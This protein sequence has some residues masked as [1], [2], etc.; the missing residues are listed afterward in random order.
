M[1]TTETWIWFLLSRPMFTISTADREMKTPTPTRHP[2]NPTSPKSGNTE[3]FTPSTSTHSSIRPQ[4]QLPQRQPNLQHPT[5]TSWLV[6]ALPKAHCTIYPTRTEEPPLAQNTNTS[7]ITKRTDLDLSHSGIPI[8]EFFPKDAKQELSTWSDY[9]VDLINTVHRPPNASA[10]EADGITAEIELLERLY[11]DGIKGNWLSVQGGVGIDF[12]AGLAAEVRHWQEIREAMGRGKLRIV[13]RW[14]ESILRDD[15]DVDMDMDME[16]GDFEIS[17]M[18]MGD[19]GRGSG[20]IGLKRTTRSEARKRN[21]GRGA[22]AGTNAESLMPMPSSSLL[23]GIGMPSRTRARPA[24]TSASGGLKTSIAGSTSRLAESTS[25]MR[26]EDTSG[27][28]LDS[29][30][31]EKEKKKQGPQAQGKKEGK[32]R[33]R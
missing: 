32:G 15:S 26:E 25:I 24:G 22:G 7:T 28:R 16:V 10:K 19:A 3:F 11:E 31:P 29:K 9:I 23:L 13:M 20:G 1:Q 33:K 12:N 17:G 5:P 4:P 27:V 18:G 8:F 30:S 2:I 6:F 14:T 21:G